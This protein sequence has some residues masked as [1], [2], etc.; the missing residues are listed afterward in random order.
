MQLWPPNSTASYPHSRD[1][2]PIIRFLNGTRFSKVPILPDQP[3]PPPTLHTLLGEEKCLSLPLLQLILSQSFVWKYSMALCFS[4]A[5]FFEKNCSQHRLPITD[6][7]ISYLLLCGAE[8]WPPCL[9]NYPE[10]QIF[11]CLAV[12]RIINCTCVELYKYSTLGIHYLAIMALFN[13]WTIWKDKC[14]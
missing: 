6:I 10:N 8:A 13:L 11:C 14:L 1:L 5:I 12:K 2:R 3:Q 9:T 7:H 4:L